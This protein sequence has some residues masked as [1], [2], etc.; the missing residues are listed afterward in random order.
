MKRFLALF[1]A[2]LRHSF[3]RLSFNVSRFVLLRESRCLLSI[4]ARTAGEYVES[5]RDDNQSLEYNGVVGETFCSTT[6]GVQENSGEGRAEE[7]T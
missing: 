2:N 7:V 5:Q 1:L 6:E 3:V 4:P